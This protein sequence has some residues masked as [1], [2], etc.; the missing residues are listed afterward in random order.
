MGTVLLA[1]FNGTAA[2]FAEDDRMFVLRSI[3]R[4]FVDDIDEDGDGEITWHEFESS[5]NHPTLVELFP[6]LARDPNLA[7]VVFNA[8]DSEG[9]GVA[10][11][12][13]FLRGLAI[14]TKLLNH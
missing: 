7:K 6:E 13:D 3:I 14:R 4:S 10:P 5:L 2:K 8:F 12:E 9:L 1:I 11:I